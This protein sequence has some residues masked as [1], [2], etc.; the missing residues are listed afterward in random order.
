MTAEPM[1]QDQAEQHRDAEAVDD[2]REHVARLVV[3]AEPVPVAERAVGIVDA[4]RI[5]AAALSPW[6]YIHDGFAGAGLGMSLLTVR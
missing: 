1:R 3:G 2:A 5:A 4:L 6:S